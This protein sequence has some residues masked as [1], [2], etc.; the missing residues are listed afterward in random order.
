MLCFGVIIESFFEHMDIFTVLFYQPIF[1]LIIVFYRAFGGDLGLAIIAIALLSRIILFPLTRRQIQMAQTSRDMQDEMKSIKE[2]HKQ[3][4]EK[5]N[6]EIMKL[7]AKHAPQQLSGCLGLIVQFILLINIYHVILDLISKG[8]ESF[9][10]VAYPFVANL[11]EDKDIN[12]S[13]LGVIDLGAVPGQIGFSD[14]SAIFPYILLAI[15]VGAAQFAST[16]V[17]MGMRKKKAAEQ[18]QK[19]EK[20]S[21]KKQS[22]NKDGQEKKGPQDFGEA[23]QNATEL[24]MKLF[25]LLFVFLSFQ[26]QAGVSL[27]WTVQSGFVII[28]QLITDR[29]FSDSDEKDPK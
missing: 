1:N 23:M 26:F 6:E 24:N 13:F 21:Q 7:Q 20:K 18:E 22:K 5:Q 28:Q 29:F 9:N 17:L 27:Y 25:P 4:K 19:T 8:A 3:D 10:K 12:T 15:T 16:R 14:L 11:P 2:K